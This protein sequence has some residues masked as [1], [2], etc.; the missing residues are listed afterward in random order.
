M[1]EETSVP[2]PPPPPNPSPPLLEIVAPL[3][4]VDIVAPPLSSHP[5]LRTMLETTSSHPELPSIQ[6]LEVMAPG[7]E[8]EEVVAL[9]SA[10]DPSICHA[11]SGNNTLKVLSM[12]ASRL[13][14]S[15]EAA[16]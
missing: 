14:A 10:L 12:E 11:A 7:I 9:L 16:S 5:K 6:S 15:V 1:V 8:S 13:P 2:N 3:L 4:L